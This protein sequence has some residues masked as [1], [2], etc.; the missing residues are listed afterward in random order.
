[1]P[2][3]QTAAALSGVDRLSRW[4]MEVAE[5]TDGVTVVNDAYNAN[6][7]SVRAALT[8]LADMTAGARRRGWAVLGEM[9]ELG[10]IAAGEHRAIG[11]LTTSLGVQRVL[12]VGPGGSVVDELYAGATAGR[13]PGEVDRVPSVEA[14]TDL[15]R[16]EIEPGDVVLVKASRAAGLERIAETLIAEG[17]AS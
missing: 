5:L 10:A 7:D 12:A 2:V 8:T 3:E 15:L 14:A 11:R 4:R 6:P 17:T 13:S 9:G 1:V 16:A